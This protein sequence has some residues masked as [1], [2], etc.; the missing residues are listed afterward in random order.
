[1]LVAAFVGEVWF[2]SGSLVDRF[3][4]PFA[5]VVRAVVI[6][7]FEAGF[8]VVNPSWRTEDGVDDC[9]D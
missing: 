1:M 7:R 9:F 4:V 8:T 2:N 5:I 6:L 3:C